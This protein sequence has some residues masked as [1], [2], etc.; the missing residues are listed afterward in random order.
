MHLCTKFGD[1]SSI[2]Y[3]VIAL[4]VYKITDFDL[5]KY[6]RAVVDSSSSYYNSLTLLAYKFK[7]TYITLC[8]S[9]WTDSQTEPISIKKIRFYRPSF[10]ILMWLQWVYCGTD[11]ITVIDFD[12]LYLSYLISRNILP[13]NI[14]HDC[15]IFNLLRKELKPCWG[16]QA[17]LGNPMGLNIWV[18]YLKLYTGCN[19]DLSSNWCSKLD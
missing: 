19:F 8:L 16:V 10:C 4:N 11:F 18:K 17:N 6:V 3:P 14:S 2:L 5:E 1:P 9:D 15:I 13:R 12:L 7:P